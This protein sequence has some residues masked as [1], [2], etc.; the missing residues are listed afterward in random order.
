MSSLGLEKRPENLA[1]A[2]GIWSHWLRLTDGAEP[3]TESN[4]LWNAFGKRTGIKGSTA[5][6]VR[7]GGSPL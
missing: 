1:K 5:G 7:R 6:S 4:L 2:E 3:R